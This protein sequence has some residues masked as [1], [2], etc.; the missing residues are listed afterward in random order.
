MDEAAELRNRA[1]MT[2][3]HIIA[4]TDVFDTRDMGGFAMVVGG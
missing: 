2:G 4:R 1:L 3:I